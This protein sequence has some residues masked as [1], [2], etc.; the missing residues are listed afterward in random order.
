MMEAAIV[1]FVF[2]LLCMLSEAPWIHRPH[3]GVDEQSWAM[4]E[5]K[6]R[7]EG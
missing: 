1:L 4:R 7:R 2:A 3:P 6:K 5:F